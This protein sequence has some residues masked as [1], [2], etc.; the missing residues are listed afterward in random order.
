MPAIPVEAFILGAAVA[1][2][3]IGWG[4]RAYLAARQVR[5]SERAS[6]QA[7]RRF[8]TYTKHHP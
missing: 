1:G 7:A 4:V 5:E 8:Y 6:W 3:V 2:A